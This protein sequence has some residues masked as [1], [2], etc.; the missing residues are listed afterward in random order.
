MFTSIIP[1]YYWK[2]ISKQSDNLNL[3]FWVPGQK[4][5]P[6]PVAGEISNCLKLTSESRDE[7]S[8]L[9]FFT[10]CLKVLIEV[11]IYKLPISWL[12]GA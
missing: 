12:K 11:Q 9:S 8:K 10:P 2:Q 7:I 3:V 6:S 5:S 1:Y 4:A